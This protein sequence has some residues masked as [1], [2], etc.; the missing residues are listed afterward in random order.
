M[1]RFSTADRDQAMTHTVSYR[2]VPMARGLAFAFHHI[3][4]HGGPVRIYSA[5][6]RDKVIA[7][8]NREFGTSLH[9]QQWLIDAYRRDPVHFAPANPVDR[10]SHCLRSDGNPAYRDSRGRLIAAGGRLPWYELGVD[11]EDIDH[12]GKVGNDVN[13]FLAAAHRLGYPFVRP[14]AS[15][16]EGHHVVLTRSPVPV[17]EAWNQISKERAAA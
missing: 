1:R 12:D 14:Y 9:G 15:G 10:T 7:E 5:D 4:L 11:L 16:A 3:S 17:L 2:N 6:R 8:H 13:Q